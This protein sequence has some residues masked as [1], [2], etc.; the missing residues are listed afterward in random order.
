VFPVEAF[1][2]IGDTHTV[3]FSCNNSA[4]T[5]TGPGAGY[6][7]TGCFDMTVNVQDITQGTPT[8]ILSGTCGG[9]GV[10]IQGGFFSCT[11][12]SNPIC[13]AGSA[14]SSGTC[15]AVC[16][17]GFTYSSTDGLCHAPPTGSPPTC[18]TGSTP[19]TGANGTPTDCVEAPT[20]ASRN[21]VTATIVS[22]APNAFRFD[23]SGFI[24]ATSSGMCPAGTTLTQNVNLT[25]T[26]GATLTGPACAFTL[27]A[28]KK[29]LEGTSLTIIPIGGCGGAIPTGFTGLIGGTPCFF[30]I[31]ATGITVLKTGVD[32]TTPGEPVTGTPVP[33]FPTGSTYACQNG[34]LTATNVPVP[35]IVINVHATNGVFPTNCIPVSRVATP[36]TPTATAGTP[37]S[38]PTP[39]PSPTPTSPAGGPTA[40]ATPAPASQPAFCQPSGTADMQVTTDSNGIAGDFGTSV[41]FGARATPP[42]VLP[43][44]DA[45]IVGQFL[46]DQAALANVPMYVTFHFIFG[47]VPCDTGVTNAAGTASCTTNI[48][49]QAAGSVV[50]VSVAFILDCTEYDTSTSFTVGAPPTG[51]PTP[52]PGLA[53]AAAPAGLCV[54]R[55]SFGTLMVT[56]T[57]AATVNSQPALSTGPVTLGSFGLATSTPLPTIAPPTPVPIPTTAVPTSTPVPTPT[58]TPTPTS[59]PTATPTNTSTPTPT[60]TPHP[61]SFSLDAVR[62]ATANNPGN[63]QGLDTVAPHQKVRLMLYYTI[64]GLPK[65]VIRITTYEI[66]APDGRDVFSVSFK[67]KEHAGDVG[68][69]IRFTYFMP[70]FGLPFGVYV[71]RGSLSFAGHKQ[72]RTWQFAITGAPL[73][74][75]TAAHDSDRRDA[76]F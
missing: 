43:G 44:G 52:T 49:S 3:T 21:T 9:S 25:P 2:A 75:V 19:V 76:V 69:F 53:A 38:T 23:F 70:P 47:D 71:F 22:G 51:S 28:Q 66:V 8:N 26:G 24:G 37:T 57:Y 46:V 73:H 63:R 6:P 50:P 15:G 12:V 39:T 58:F 62:V 41:E 4:G 31:K 35:G 72:T 17:S 54:L 64:L 36:G 20:T 29:Y 59:T 65:T 55:T 5:L 48:D 60:P 56:A 27:S 45:T 18:P 10:T 32:C 67:G 13:A 7:T 16:P 30:K 68:R 34:N 61:L 14:L 11:P 40:T 42:F 74:A 1:N 33:G